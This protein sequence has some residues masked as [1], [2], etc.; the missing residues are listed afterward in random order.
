[1]NE[2]DEPAAAPIAS[3]EDLATATTGRIDRHVVFE[4]EQVMEAFAFSRGD[5][6]RTMEVT[7]SDVTKLLNLDA[8]KE[9]RAFGAKHANA[10]DALGAKPRVGT[11]F[12]ALVQARE[13][14]RVREA[15]GHR[16]KAT[17]RPRY[18]LASPMSSASESY[19][20]ERDLA[21]ELAG[22]L[23]SLCG[24]DVYYAGSDLPTRAAFDA[25]GIAYA[26][27]YA[28]LFAASQFVLLVT[29]PPR[30]PSSVWVEAGLALGFRIPSTYFVPSSLELPYILR[31]AA[32]EPNGL[33]KVYPTGGKV[34]E[35]HRLVRANK[36]RLFE[37]SSR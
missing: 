32:E 30:E 20:K 9:H 36:R 8:T 25:S 23:E 34:R 17:G 31:Q 2:D 33:V 28:P 37:P 14:A 3:V 18:F 19:R 21:E 12:I 15:G 16:P 22:L 13:K 6:A 11:N 27:N 5:L 26:D 35:A 1:M 24:A 29:S 7:Q 10:L 4:I